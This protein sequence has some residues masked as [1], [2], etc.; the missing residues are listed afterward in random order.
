MKKLGNLLHCLIFI[1]P[2]ILG[3]IIML[4]YSLISRDKSMKQ[5]MDFLQSSEENIVNFG[6]HMAIAFWLIVIIM[7]Y[8]H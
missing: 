2:L 1:P 6:Y 3:G 4:I 8:L 5:M 7:I